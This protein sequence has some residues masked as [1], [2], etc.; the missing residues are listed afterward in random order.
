MSFQVLVKTTPHMHGSYS[1][2][3]ESREAR[4]AFARRPDIW[5]YHYGEDD[6]WDWHRGGAWDRQDENVPVD[7]F[8]QAVPDVPKVPAIPT[9]ETGPDE[10]DEED[11]A[12][13]G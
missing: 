7:G 4:D 2:T 3:C 9:V 6:G 1:V 12:R 10:G 8:S 5:W 13:W 11:D